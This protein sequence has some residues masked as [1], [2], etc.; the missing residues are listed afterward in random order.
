MS[1]VK[2]MW[3]WLL[4]LVMIVGLLLSLLPGSDHW[5]IFPVAFYVMLLGG[6]IIAYR[7]LLAILEQ[8][9][10]TAGVLVVISIVGC[11][12]LGF[13]KAAAL[14]ALMMFLGEWLEERTLAK[15]RQSFR[16][17]MELVPEKSVAWRNGQWEEIS[18][19]D[20]RVGDRLLVKPGQGIPADGVVVKGTAAV[21]EAALT[22]ESMPVDK[23][24]G[25]PVWQGTMNQFGS[26]EFLVEKAGSATTMGKIIEAV[27]HAQETKGSTQRLADRFAQY[28]TPLILAIAGGTWYL[29]DDL[30]RTMTVL[31]IACPCALVLATPTAIVASV[32]NVAKRGVL[33]KGGKA[34]EALSQVTVVCLDK[35]GTLT[36]G[37]P[38][39]VHATAFKGRE[40]SDVLYYASAAESHSEHPIAVS[41]R[42]YTEQEGIHSAF[43]IEDFQ[44][45]IG[46][47][48]QAKVN[49][50]LVQVGNGRLG[51]EDVEAHLFLKEQEGMGHTALLVFVDGDCIGGIALGDQV[52]AEAARATG[53]LRALGISK[54]VM[55]TGDHPTAAHFTGE[56]ISV[57]EVHAGLLPQEKLAL[58][59]SYQRSGHV[60][61]MVGDGINDAPA[62]IAADVGIAMGAAGTDLAIESSEIALMGDKLTLLPE[63]I[64]ISR[65]TMFIVRQNILYFAVLFN[66]VGIG[67]A[68]TGLISP[69]VGAIIHN[70]ASLFV[71]ANSARLLH[72]G[73]QEK[74]KLMSKTM[75]A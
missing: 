68:M 31:V 17:L 66:L 3:I 33:V 65:R 12:Y 13:Y 5:F 71:V 57:D 22:G 39:L 26:L 73:G 43:Q 25:D 59:Q 18:T 11:A 1:F 27:Y 23:S 15:T 58:I 35:T 24:T 6:G 72:Y 21:N 52:R 55:L 75:E 56:Q 45:V 28:F 29:T 30:I 67:L 38:R 64:E 49:G 16:E 48:V 62:L 63:I 9:R 37:K 14:V 51:F 8:R 53:S 34:I 54:V 19:N 2:R 7:S 69:V 42:E 70:A 36:Y 41:I 46:T 74:E 61:A 60:V 4:P 47:G 44:Q 32:G 50:K 10:I 40:I 20:V